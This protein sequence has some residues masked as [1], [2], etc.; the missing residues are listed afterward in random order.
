MPLPVTDE[1]AKAA[2]ACA[3]LGKTA[4]ETASGGAGYV[5]RVLDN[6]PQDLVG[7]AIGDRLRVARWEQAQGL[8]QVAASSN[9][10]AS[11]GLMGSGSGIP[12]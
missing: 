9:G 4:L 2:A 10:A 5:A 6:L 11:D 8:L 12:L 7:W 3:E 1:Q